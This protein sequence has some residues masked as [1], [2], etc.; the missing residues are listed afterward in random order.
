MQ[1]AKPSTI[2]LLLMSL[3]AAFGVGCGDSSSA[4]PAGKQPAGDAPA[5]KLTVVCT[6]TMIK[7]LA[8]QIA[9]DLAEVKGIMK[10]GEDPHIYEMRPRD[11]QAIKS[12][13][14]VL[15]NGL[16]LEAQIDHVVEQHASGKVVRLAEDPRI[17]PRGSEQFQGAPDPHCW[18]NIQYFK[19]YAQNARDAL[20]ELDT[21]NARSYRD[22]TDAYMAQLDELE[23]WVKE[24][25]VAVPRDQRILVTSHDAFGYFGDA[26]GVE[27]YAVIGMS[28]EA[29]PTGRDKIRLEAL[30]RQRRAKAVF[31]ETSVSQ[32][33][34]DMVRQIAAATGAKV[35][36]TL[37]S[38]SLGAPESEAGTYVGMIRHNVRTLV[39][40]LK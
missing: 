3:S 9:G 15:M 26:Y 40:A 5:G 8:D 31:V 17:K 32:A 12:A 10:T 4:G 22:R 38:D 7:D 21:T 23:A 27:V 1:R 16:H 20:S 35:G 39:E 36:G 29:I 30:V 24:Q 13:D 11:T 33:L 25:L 2:F 28:T 14:L 37:Y 34:N 6:T 19:V 18:F